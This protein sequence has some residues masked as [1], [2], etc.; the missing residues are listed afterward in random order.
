MASVLI[1]T[2]IAD[3]RADPRRSLPDGSA[4]DVPLFRFGLRQLLMFVAVICALLGAVVTTNGL[5]ALLL[6][7]AAAVVAMHV[8]ATALGSRLR[9]ET[10]AEQSQRWVDLKSSEVRATETQRS[11]RIA[12]I[13]S[14]P[15]SPWHGRGSTYLP[16][17]PRIVLAAMVCGGLAGAVSLDL[18]IGRHASAPGIAIGAVSISVLCG[19][20]SFLC[21]N[22]YGVFRHGFRE[23][24]A[25]QR[26]DDAHVS[27]S[28]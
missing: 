9:S 12:A 14:A 26:K 23:A 1:D 19:W 10:D 22:F 11:A 21:G 8:F 13:Q 27:R 5:T 28:R 2:G 15:R 20:A 7:T 3:N 25:E 6:W 4:A 17:L 24:I 18:L 16:W